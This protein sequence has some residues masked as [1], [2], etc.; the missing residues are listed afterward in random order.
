MAYQFLLA[1]NSESESPR[2]PSWRIF[3]YMIWFF[4]NLSYEYKPG[5]YTTKKHYNLVVMW[6]DSGNTWPGL[7]FQLYYLPT[8]LHFFLSFFSFWPHCPGGG[9]LFLWPGV[10]PSS[11]ALAARSLN[12]WMAG[13]LNCTQ[14]LC[15]IFLVYKMDTA[16]IMVPTTRA[17]T[18]RIVLAGVSA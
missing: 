11:P 14:L 12:H 4:F 16:I 18:F 7:K 9:I 3:H 2:T 17:I 15:L 8:V 5:L 1:L 10:K 6:A 13:E